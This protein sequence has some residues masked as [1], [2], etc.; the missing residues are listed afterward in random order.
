M[1]SMQMALMSSAAMTPTFPL[2]VTLVEGYSYDPDNAYAYVE[3]KRDGSVS[4][5]TYGTYNPRWISTTGATVGDNYWVRFTYVS[6]EAHNYGGLTAG[7]WYQIN[8]T[9]VLGYVAAGQGTQT[10]VYRIDIARD[11]GGTQIVATDTAFTFNAVVE[12]PL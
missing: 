3:I 6:G 10:G 4:V 1:S 7:T 2:S 12:P 8:T 11:S 9:R 5:Q